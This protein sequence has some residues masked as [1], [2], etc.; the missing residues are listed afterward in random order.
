MEVV[1]TTEATRRAKL[2]SNCHHRQ[3]NAALFTR[4][5]PFLTPNQQCQALKKNFCPSSGSEKGG[6]GG[7][8]ARAALCRRRHMRGEN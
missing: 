7:Q 8:P 5:M 4:R 3:T 1:E 6:E 2:Q